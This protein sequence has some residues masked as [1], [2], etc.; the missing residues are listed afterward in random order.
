MEE[1][2]RYLA[3]SLIFLTSLFILIGEDWRYIGISLAIDYIGIF[4]FSGLNIPFSVALVKLLEGWMATAILSTTVSNINV[5]I[6]ENLNYINLAYTGKWISPQK[7]FRLFLAL[8]I[9]VTIVVNLRF[10]NQLFPMID[11]LQTI[12]GFVLLAYGILIISFRHTIYFSALG[13]LVFIGGFETIF[14]ALEPSVLLLGLIAG[15]DLAIASL[16]AWLLYI[17]SGAAS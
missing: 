16:C 13:L 15:V 11:S 17:Q 14:V 3:L 6:D 9:G 8:L 2:I 10:L 5:S 4:L 12:A 1:A 7:L